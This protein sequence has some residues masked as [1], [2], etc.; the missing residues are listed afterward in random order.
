MFMEQVNTAGETD[1]EVPAGFTA[2]LKDMVLD[3]PRFATI[4]V[5]DVITVSLDLTNCNVWRVNGA[6]IS[7]G[8][9]RWVGTQSFNA[10]MHLTAWAMPYAFRASGYLL[11]N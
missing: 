4:D 3:I 8:T 11:T 5:L 10:V 1:Y 2:V 6:N 7:T 9:Y